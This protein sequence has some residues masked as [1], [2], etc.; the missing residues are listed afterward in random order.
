MTD[1][2]ILCCAVLPTCCPA[3]PTFQAAAA[4]EAERQR[5]LA[6]QRLLW[7][8]YLEQQRKLAAQ[9]AAQVTPQLCMHTASTALVASRPFG[10]GA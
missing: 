6:E 2:S 1:M 5:L 8:H 10:S 4:A 9:Q 7:Q 3:L